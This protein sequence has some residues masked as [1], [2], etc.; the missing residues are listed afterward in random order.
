M[1]IATGIPNAVP[2]ADG[3]ALVEFARRA[4]AAGFS[5]LGTIGRIVFDGHEELIA[6]A[7][8][9]GATCR[10]R[11][12]TTVLIGPPRDAALLAK[13]AATL[14]SVSGGRFTLGLGVGYRDDDFRATGTLDRYPRRGAVL[15]EMVATLREVWAGKG[16]PAPI[17][18][19]LAGVGPPELLLGG[20]APPA[21]RRAGRLADAFLSVPLPAEAV[22]AQ[23]ATVCEAGRPAPRLAVP[24]Y[25]A[26]GDGIE[27]GRQ[28]MASYYAFGGEDF[29]RQMVASLLTTPEAIR[30]RVAEIEAIGADELY[31]WPQATDPAQVDLLREALDG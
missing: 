6:L 29:V 20:G 17:G 30:A 18:P 8:A 11:F 28:G 27:A 13:Q 4:D 7:A 1:K 3:P 19:A 23:Y 12:A 5:S 2:G 31:F 25:F 24:S 26:L 22:Q 15:D 10:I 16:E 14:Q 21:L 9:A